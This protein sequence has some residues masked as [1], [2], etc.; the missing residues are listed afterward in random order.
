MFGF[1]YI[2]V[3]GV[4]YIV[5][6]F[7]YTKETARSIYKELLAAK[8]EQHIEFAQDPNPKDNKEMLLCITVPFV[9]GE[10]H[11]AIAILK[12]HSQ[13]AASTRHAQLAAELAA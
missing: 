3:C 4:R 9:E 6:K 7:S 13:G 5:S 12:K 1:N 2:T 11:P 8:L 10:T